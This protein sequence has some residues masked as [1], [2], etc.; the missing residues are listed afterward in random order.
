MP[1]QELIQMQDNV[2]DPDAQSDNAQADNA[3][4]DNV[5]DPDAANV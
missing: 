3:Q 1:E 2:E 4:A 5:E